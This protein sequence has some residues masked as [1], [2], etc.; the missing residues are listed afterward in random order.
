MLS[1]LRSSYSLCAGSLLVRERYVILLIVKDK[2]IVSPMSAQH[3]IIIYLNNSET[4]INGGFILFFQVPTGFTPYILPTMSPPV[5][6]TT[7]TEPC[8][9][10]HFGLTI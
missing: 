9:C 8:I 5:L 4:K 10:L 2:V 6:E 7:V 3:V 1:A